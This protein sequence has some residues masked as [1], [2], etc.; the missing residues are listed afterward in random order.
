MKKK[1]KRIQ[2]GNWEFK[3]EKREKLPNLERTIQFLTKSTQKQ[4]IIYIEKKKLR[5][6]ETQLALYQL[7]TEIKLKQSQETKITSLFKIPPT[8][9]QNQANIN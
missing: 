6:M 1:R 4:E 3:V 9:L 5:S 7:G 8:H 2:P